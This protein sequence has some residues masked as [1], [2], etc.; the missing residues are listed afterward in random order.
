M[1]KKRIMFYSVYL[2]NITDWMLMLNIFLYEEVIRVLV[3]KVFDSFYSWF[4]ILNKNF[5][6]SIY[7]YSSGI[8]LYT[9]SKNK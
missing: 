5:L 7:E 6:F 9:C 8:F 2:Y 3:L 1:V 4:S